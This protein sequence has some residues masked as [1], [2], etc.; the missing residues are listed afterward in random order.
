MNKSFFNASLLIVLLVTA[1]SCDFSTKSATINIHN[2]ST[3]SITKLSIPSRSDNW[4]VDVL[5]P[6]TNCTLLYEWVESNSWYAELYFTMNELE[7]GTLSQE[8]I[9]ADT[10]DRYKPYKRIIDGDTVIVKIYNN[11]W[12]W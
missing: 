3:Y 4:F 1:T 8:Q 5:E 9:K 7:Y 2:Y 10:P 12:E 6:N 11:R